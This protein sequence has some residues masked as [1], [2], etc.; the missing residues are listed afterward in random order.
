MTT[1]DEKTLATLTK[2]FEAASSDAATDE[3]LASGLDDSQRA[4]IVASIPKD[5]TATIE[6]M[7]AGMSES[8]ATVKVALKQG[9]EMTYEVDFVREG[10][11]WVVCSIASDFNV[12]GDVDASAGTDGSAADP[13]DADAATDEA[14]AEDAA[15]ADAPAA[16][17]PTA[18]PA[19][20]A[21]AQ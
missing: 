5:A 12:S 3:F 4:V 15:A 16:E 17:D 14:P 1:P 10:L 13:T 20:E 8:K 18:E 9:G 21:A 2:L 11:G 19:G 7:D 6:G